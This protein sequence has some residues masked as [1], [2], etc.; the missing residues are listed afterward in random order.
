MDADRDAITRFQKAF[1]PLVDRLYSIADST[2]AEEREELS[3]IRVDYYEAYV[4]HG[5]QFAREII[6]TRE[7][8]RTA[9]DMARSMAKSEAT[10]PREWVVQRIAAQ[11]ATKARA[12]TLSFR[13]VNE[14]IGRGEHAEAELRMRLRLRELYEERFEMS[15][16]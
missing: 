5:E 9:I 12:V 6:R 15:V 16:V 10:T 11:W 8:W 13:R 1:E 4:S 2:L 14:M 3:R 7:D